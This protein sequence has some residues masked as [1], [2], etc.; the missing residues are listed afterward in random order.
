LPLRAEE[1][2]SVAAAEQEDKALQVGVQVLEAI[3]GVAG[4]L[5]QRGAEAGGVAGPAIG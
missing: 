4:E 1:R 2:F 3:G 5:F